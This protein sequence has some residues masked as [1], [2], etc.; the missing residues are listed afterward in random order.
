MERF[1]KS[2]ED[3]EYD[4]NITFAEI[5]LPEKLHEI[6]DL[7]LEDF[8]TTQESANSIF[9]VLV[10]VHFL[11]TALFNKRNGIDDNFDYTRIIPIYKASFLWES[12]A[13]DKSNLKEG[14]AKFRLAIPLMMEKISLQFQ[15]PE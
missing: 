12:L 9:C 8:S 15:S 11:N 10:I 2:I 5:P 7:L 14:L 1:E 6:Y 4:F 3:F 13:K